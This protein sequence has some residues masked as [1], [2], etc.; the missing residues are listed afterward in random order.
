M[1][2]IISFLKNAVDRGNAAGTYGCYMFRETGVYA[3]NRT[4]LAGVTVPYGAE[5]NIPA[6]PLDAAL[7]R[8]KSIDSI[9][10]DENSVTLRSGRLRSTIKIDQTEAVEIPVLPDDRIPCPALLS[11]A[12]TVAKD[13]CGEEQWQVC[14]RIWN[15]RVT[16]FAPQRGVDITVPGLAVENPVLI[17]QDT[18]EF[19]VDH[20]PDELSVVGSSIFFFWDDGRWMR[21]QTYNGAMPE[22]TVRQIIDSA[23]DEA[24]VNID[25][26]FKQA[27]DDI[28]AMCDKAFSISPE[29]FVGRMGED[30]SHPTSENAVAHAIELPEEHLS[31]WTKEI[32]EPVMKHATA[33]NPLNWPKPCLFVAEGL[34]GV[35]MGRGRW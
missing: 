8:M 1:H 32:I 20:K 12:L 31:I 33:W 6:G 4:M 16:A 2:D 26:A 14:I 17:T 9:T 22:G 7:A 23:G 19:I 28:A 18:A 13:F 3:Y 24:P 11:W 27:Y 35:V 30:P 25:N 5:Y 21:A 34:R 29:G 15:D 10:M